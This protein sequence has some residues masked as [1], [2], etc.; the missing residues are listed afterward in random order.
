MI[1]FT[2]DTHFDHAN[3]IH[4]CGRPYEST[5]QMN[6]DM[7]EKWNRKVTNN[8]TVYIMGDM[9]FRSK[10]SE[11]ILRR[12][13]GKKHLTIGNHDTW[14]K[15]VDADKYFEKISH[16]ITVSDGRRGLVLCHYPQICWP[17]QRRS[18]MIHG[19][20]HADTDGD[21]WP[22]ITARENLLNAGVDING[23]EPVTFDEL[24]ENNR[25]FKAEHSGNGGIL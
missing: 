18:Y 2:A 8:D 22:L 14:L 7:I 6:E 21:Y 3:I 4:L 23:F 25:K 12:L 11:A 9:F 19:H 24:V 20:I 13:R 5:Q 16:Y 10:D 15:R 1:Y 17:H